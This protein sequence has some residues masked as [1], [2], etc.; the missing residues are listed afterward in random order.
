MSAR[1]SRSRTHATAVNMD[2]E[3]IGDPLEISALESVQ[4]SLRRGGDSV[5]SRH[6]SRQELKILHRYHFSR[7]LRASGLN[8]T[9]G[10]TNAAFPL[11]GAEMI[12]TGDTG[13]CC[14]CTHHFLFPTSTTA[15]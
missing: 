4:W 15:P 2:G 6:H 11:S 12:V 13:I 5:I 9:F 10:V 14:S 8:P 3:I 7:Y 1:L